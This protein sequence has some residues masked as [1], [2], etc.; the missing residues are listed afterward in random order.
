M[1]RKAKPNTAEVT[2]RFRVP[3]GV[4]GADAK[5]LIWNHLTGT[6][7]LFLDPDEEEKFGSAPIKPVA[8]AGRIIRPQKAA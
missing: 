5:R 7:E 3:K 6:A 8:V 1:P 4:S 2:L